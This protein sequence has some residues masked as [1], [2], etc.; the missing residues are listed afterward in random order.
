[1]KVVFPKPDSPATFHIVSN[2]GIIGTQEN[3]HNS[4][5][6]A[7]LSNDFVPSRVSRDFG[8][9]GTAREAYRWFGNYPRRV[10]CQ[11][12]LEEQAHLRW[13]CQLASPS[14]WYQISLAG[15]AELRGSCSEERG[16]PERLCPSWIL[17]C[18]LDSQAFDVDE[19]QFKTS[20]LLSRCRLTRWERTCERSQL[21]QV[22]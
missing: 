5:I 19:A 18:G 3:Y 1:M 14:P 4:E 15:A 16:E 21:L 8:L 9:D 12:N 22:R 11:V 10:S 13:Q 17:A 20:R 6:R 2:R 7:A